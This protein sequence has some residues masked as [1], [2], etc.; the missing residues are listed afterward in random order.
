VVLL[1][2]HRTAGPWPLAR[3]VAEYA[4]VALLAAL[5]VP[6]GDVDQHLASPTTRAEARH[7]AT[8][9]PKADAGQDQPGVIRAGAKLVRAVTAAAKAVTGAIGWVADLWRQADAKT[10]PPRRSPTTTAA[11]TGDAMPHSPAMASPATR[12]PL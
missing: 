8:A 3:A 2:V 5:L 6:A 4:A 1:T 7:A 10:D 11:P 9:P 12:R